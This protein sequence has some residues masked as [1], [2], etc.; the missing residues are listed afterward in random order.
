MG[1]N[2]VA[3]M[4]VFGTILGWLVGLPFAARARP[5][6]LDAVVRVAHHRRLITVPC[7][8][9]LHSLSLPCHYPLQQRFL[10]SFR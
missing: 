1:L 10:F 5:E 9:G 4:L 3:H 7:V 8:R 6:P 2:T